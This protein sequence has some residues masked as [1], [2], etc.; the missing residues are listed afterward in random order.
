MP[1]VLV[2][3]LSELGQT[4]LGPYSLVF[5][6]LIADQGK[7]SMM[8][9]TRADSNTAINLRRT[10]YCS[11]NFIPA[12]KK[13]L[14]NCVLLGYP[15]DS[16]KE[17]MKDSI[18]KLTPSKREDNGH[19]MTYPDIV[20]D[21]F[22]VF[23]CTWDFSVP[24]KLV[25]GCENFLLKVDKILLKTQYKDAIVH[26]MDAKSFPKIPIGYGFR[27]NLN[28]WFTHCQKPFA[29]PVPESKGASVNTILYAAKRFDP[30]VEWT[31]EAA[32]KIVRVPRLFL[33]RVIAGVVEAAKKEGLAVITAEFMDKVRDKRRR[34]KGE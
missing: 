26:G 24:S 9:I 30:S 33:K 13:F 10:R 6:H 2:S 20:E 18:F 15:G 32:E 17:K 7:Y 1:I 25:N 27:D 34:E 3:T 8:L 4:N 29:Y 11:I 12:D 5:P 21:A 19:D 23:E 22:Q 16:T 31:E 14:E 28:F